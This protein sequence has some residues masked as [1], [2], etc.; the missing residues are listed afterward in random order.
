MLYRALPFDADRHV[1]VHVHIP[2]T[3]GSTLVAMLEAAFGAER[4][5]TLP[6]RNLEGFESGLVRLQNDMRL[7]A[8]RTGQ[9]FA[10]VP[11]RARASRPAP[12]VVT[13][14]VA[15]PDFPRDG[16][17]PLPIALV[18]RPADRLASEYWFTKGRLPAAT[19]RVG[20]LKK[21]LVARLSLDE[22]ADHVCR[23]AGRL[24]VDNQCRFLAG[25]PSFARARKVIDEEMFLAAPLP[26]LDRFVELLEA[27]LGLEL[28]R[29]GP[30][31][32]STLRPEAP[33]MDPS[34][35]EAVD[36][37]MREDAQLC[38][39][40]E[41]AFTALD[42]RSAP[43]PIATFSGEARRAGAAAELTQ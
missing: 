41:D 43:R 13:G 6:G 1:L 4:V 26:R 29:L 8:E 5:R 33:A 38:D 7:W 14:H 15:L 36:R 18:R 30:R 3:G 10:S 28:P 16:R 32:A 27:G 39:Y 35:A 21:R 34:M 12:A 24:P 19:S 9:W 2:K 31:N 23:N 11:A 25:A 22:Y 42:L 17:L 37:V 40:V 20:D